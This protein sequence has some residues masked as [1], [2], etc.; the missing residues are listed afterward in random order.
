[1][2]YR[3]FLFCLISFFCI[4][5]GQAQKSNFIV[6]GEVLDSLTRSGI[7]YATLRV[8]P[9]KTNKAI[10]VATA[11]DNGKF[12]ISIPRTGSF[13][14]QFIYLGMAPVERQV[15]VKTAS[16]TLEL[17]TVLMQ[18]YST[19][20]G[21][22]TV[23]AQRPIVKA[24]IDKLSYSISE[25]P[26]AETNSLL[27]ML[28]KVPMVTV[29]GEDN[30]KVNGNG[31]FKVYVNGKLNTM[32]SANPSLI[33]KNY[34][35][36]AVK[37]V[38]VVTDPGAKYD[39]EGVAGVLNIV[40]ESNTKTSGYTLTPHINFSNFGV[41]GSVFGMAQVGKLTVSGNYGI[42]HMEPPTSTGRSER[43]VFDDDINHLLRSSSE[44]ENKGT[45][46]FGSLDAS[47]EF[48]EHNLLSL[49]AGIHAHKGEQHSLSRYEM[50][51]ADGEENYSYIQ[52]GRTESSHRG[53]NVS[54]DYQ[55]TF[56]REGQSVTLSYRFNT[57]PAYNRSTLYYTDITGTPLAPLS[58]RYSDPQNKSY[59][60][61]AQ[62]DFTTPLGKAHTLST[63]VKYIYRINRSD[64]TEY[65]R[66]SGSDFDFVLSEDGNL[67]Y[68]HRND[69]MA[70]YTEYTL[71]LKQFTARAGLRFEHSQVSVSYPDG[72]QKAFDNHF[73]D[74]VPSLSFG[75]ALSDAC[76]LKA[77]YN[78][79]IGRPDISYLSP[80]VSHPTPETQSYGNPNLNS[81]KAHNFSA[82]FSKFAPKLNI[83]ASLAYMLQTN[84]L[85]PYTFL[86]DEGIQTTTY[87]NFLHTKD[88]SL[89]LYVNWTIV[90]GTVLNLNANGNYAD[91]KAYH[92]Y[93]D[94]NAHNSGFSAGCW[95]GIR[96]D[97]PWKLKLNLHGGGSLRSI[98]L[99]GKNSGFR[100][101][102][103]NLSRSFLQGEKLTLSIMAGNFIHP[104]RT[105]RNTM[106]TDTF[107]S[108]NLS[109]V[110]FLRFGFGV[111]YRLGSLQAVVKKTARS[112]DNSDVKQQSSGNN[113]GQGNDMGGGM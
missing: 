67:R 106:L 53:I 77:G 73:N 30:I 79:R 71:K 12:S 63:G 75:Y 48:N 90:N 76:M 7:P 24:E 101:Y 58:D 22:A 46:Q 4:L 41:F 104:K 40:T 38:E 102:A 113:T 100:F 81:E 25:D 66:L 65:T 59:E 20:L 94:D 45:F 109:R 27:E 51:K 50:T 57:S 105:F 56:A 9:V 64:N 92:F 108:E 29:D 99:Q 85:T 52:S 68:R 87:G 82:G 34:P 95:G 80:Y 23:T 18:E 55:H 28:R 36:S 62:A 1:M 42:G 86:D 98:S 11:D 88:L 70:G 103:I 78:M 39:A 61:T 112:I 49:T 32:M 10:A 2:K 14:L 89:N 47:Y 17:G 43:E 16:G 5:C 21:T 13:R 96:Q 6:K 91:Y 72:S 31:S 15:E 74:V 84:G 33:L 37:K 19:T 93:G 35:A 60:H 83:N 44:N 111:R 3:F 26:D 97:L 8:V 110:D 54:T 107:R 69:I